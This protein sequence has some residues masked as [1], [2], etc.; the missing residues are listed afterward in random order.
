M[1]NQAYNKILLVFA[2][3]IGASKVVDLKVNDLQLVFLQELAN[4]VNNQQPTYPVL[5]VVK[6]GKS[7]DRDRDR[8]SLPEF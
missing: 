8:K 2:T 1:K 6:D 5:N 4:L 7:L 3:G